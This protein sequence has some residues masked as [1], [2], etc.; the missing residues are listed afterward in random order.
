MI[1]YQIL[2][3]NVVIIVWQTVRGVINEV[4]GV[5]R[6]KSSEQEYITNQKNITIKYYE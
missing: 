5:K 1:H 4:F 3:I 2:Q 6:F